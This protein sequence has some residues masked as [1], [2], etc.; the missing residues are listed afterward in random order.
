[1]ETQQ[2]CAGDSAT[3]AFGRAARNALWRALQDAHDA[4]FVF[5]FFEEFECVIERA[6]QRLAERRIGR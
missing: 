2:L 3:L 6:V 1:M 5:E 4:L